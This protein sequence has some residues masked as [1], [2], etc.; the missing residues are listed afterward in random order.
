MTTPRKPGYFEY[1]LWDRQPPGV[2]TPKSDNPKFTG[3]FERWF[4]DRQPFD[5]Y[6]E[7]TGQMGCETISW[8]RYWGP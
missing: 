3:T 6:V 2:M 7:P 4:W 5:W 8:G 1:W